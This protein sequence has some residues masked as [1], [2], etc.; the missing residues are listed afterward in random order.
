MNDNYLTS[1]V[2]SMLVI[3]LVCI[4]IAGWIA[5]PAS[6]AL[7]V[8]EATCGAINYDT[9]A[10][11]LDL[12]SWAPSEMVEAILTVG[13]AEGEI[14][15]FAPGDMLSPTG[16]S[17]YWGVVKLIE[18]TTNLYPGRWWVPRVHTDK[19]PRL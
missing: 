11:V 2:V 8:S 13:M 9:L 4:L 5:N 19:T 1:S 18:I 16:A 10:S 17:R 12:A 6:D 3:T 14:V 7:V 15:A